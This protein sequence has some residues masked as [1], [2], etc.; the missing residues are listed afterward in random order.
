MLYGRRYRELDLT[1]NTRLFTDYQPVVEQEQRAS[2]SEGFEN[3]VP[4]L[5]HIV[6]ARLFNQR[7]VFGDS[8]Y[9]L[10]SSE[11]AESLIPLSML[12]NRDLYLRRC[13][14]C[15]KYVPEYGSLYTK[16]G[17]F[18]IRNCSEQVYYNRPEVLARYTA[19][20][21]PGC[22]SKAVRFRIFP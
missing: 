11:N 12:R 18:D 7:Y 4:M 17:R 13:F 8:V 3:A 1:E 20:V 21:C 9:L 10:S 5:K 6:L 14:I 2:T 22:F 16:R 19:N 15:V